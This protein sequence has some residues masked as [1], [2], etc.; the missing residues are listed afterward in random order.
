MLS[1]EFRRLDRAGRK[2]LEAGL[3]LTPEEALAAAETA[4]KHDPFALGGIGR[5]DPFAG[6]VK[7]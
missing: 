2:A 6:A 4:S 1:I 3:A 7:V 5:V